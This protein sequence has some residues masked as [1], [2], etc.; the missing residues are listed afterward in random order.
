MTYLDARRCC[1][2]VMKGGVTSGVLYPPAIC[3]IAEKYHFMGIGGTSAGAIAACAAAAAEYRRRERGEDDGFRRLETLHEELAEPGRLLALF[4]PDAETQPTHD[5]LMELLQSGSRV[6]RFA[7]IM[8]PLRVG[9]M[10][11][12]RQ[13]LLAPMVD[14]FYGLC[15]GM[16]LGHPPSD[17]PE[18]LG[19]WL[20]RLIDDVAGKRNG[21]PLTFG[22]LGNAPIPPYLE[23]VLGP[24]S[25]RSI[26][27]K[28]VTTCVTYGRPFELPF[29]RT[30]IFAFDPA[31]WRRLFPE[32]VVQYLEAKAEAQTS[33]SLAEDGKLP[34]PVGDDMPVVVAARMSLAFPFL[35]SMVPLY[36]RN[37]HDRRGHGAPDADG[38]LERVWF[39]DGGITSN[40]PIHRF[41]AAFPRW[42][43]LA[44]NL[45][46]TD[47]KGRPDRRMDDDS[48]VYLIQR[49][50]DGSLD[51]WH[52]FGHD[53]ALWAL[54]SFG[55]A[56]FRSAQ[57]WH[58]NAYL[59]L[60]GYRG[61]VV[62]IWLRPHEG[63]TNLDMPEGVIRELARR[64]RLAGERIRDRYAETPG[65]EPLSWRGHRWTRLRSALT[66]LIPY[67]RQFEHATDHPLPG[68]E[69]ID[70]FFASLEAPPTHRFSSQEQLRAASGA[71]A[72]LLHELDQLA[73]EAEAAGTE[74]LDHPFHDGPRP[75]VEI[76]TRPPI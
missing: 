3:A 75:A 49:P 25:R 40:L 64:G 41:D 7:Q 63:G 9:W 74:D 31:E 72:R 5:L 51:L 59:R 24:G 43:T 68:D 44:I 1:D 67:L 47:A 66:G 54:L 4:R 58:D 69:V 45:Q 23:G 35:F 2:L 12:N 28:A 42:P 27:L 17:A 32:Y 22:D 52:R 36:A 39:S 48:L 71:L 14:N 10:L 18:P 26:D 57:V 55:M 53:D 76:G 15:T 70:D 29:D 56:V 38:P 6:T 73:R 11:L 21:E 19:P 65:T 33:S 30:R 13:R 60:P 62:E 46:S 37:H 16:A 8:T 20:A 61:R 34:L 50:S